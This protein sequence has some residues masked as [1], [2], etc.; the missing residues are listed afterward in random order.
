MKSSSSCTDRYGVSSHQQQQQKFVMHPHHH[1][2][3]QQQQMPHAV[4][5]TSYPHQ[6]S[7]ANEW[8]GIPL[9]KKSVDSSSM[10]H[11]KASFNNNNNHLNINNS[12]NSIR[13]HGYE[14]DD[15]SGNVAHMAMAKHPHGSS[16]IMSGRF[17]KPQTP[18]IN[19]FNVNSENGNVRSQNACNLSNTCEISETHEEESGYHHANGTCLPRIIK[20]RK[21][22][23]KDRKPLQQ[24]QQTTVNAATEKVSSSTT[25]EIPFTFSS[26]NDFMQNR[27]ELKIGNRANENI[28]PSSQQL[29]Q[30]DSNL[31]FNNDFN[32]NLIS[33][34]KN[35]SNNNNGS[36]SSSPISLSNSSL[37]SS[38]C[39]CRLCDPNCKIWAFPLRRSFSDN[40]AAEI[41]LEQYHHLN[42]IDINNRKKDVGVIG[43]N[44]IKAESNLCTN[45]SFAIMD[46]IEFNNNRNPQHFLSNTTAAA[47]T[48]Q[49]RMRSES[50]SEDSGDSGC[51]LLLSGLNISDDIISS[52]IKTVNDAFAIDS[53]STITQQL[54]N[55]NLMVDDN[56]LNSSSFNDNEQLNYMN[57]K[58]SSINQKANNNNLPVAAVTAMNYSSSSSNLMC[59]FSDQ[60]QQQTKKLGDF[61]KLF[62]MNLTP[63]CNGDS[64][65]HHKN[66]Y[67]ASLLSPMLVNKRNHNIIDINNNTNHNNNSVNSNFNNA[68]SLCVNLL[69]EDDLN[70]ERSSF[71]FDIPWK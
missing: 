17:Q 12:I 25:A 33:A 52:T 43:G 68:Q 8:I 48:I 1:H 57:N 28:M 15:C 64:N 50:L 14:F 70:D 49:S 39:S 62:A 40:A 10:R 37:S 31:F 61:D 65:S 63:S 21:R 22:R 41:E 2:Q 60:H 9:I 7:N 53:L 67:N 66:N 59:K 32:P 71:Q 51:E 18:L 42:N 36:T 35:N 38:S 11:K 24:Q 27:H 30:Y 45:S 58:L 55:F 69:N 26:T 29:L 3:Q 44:R 19:A 46:L 20:P 56:S 54:S 13:S 23:K 16:L 6:F 4:A 5:A 34:S 47:N